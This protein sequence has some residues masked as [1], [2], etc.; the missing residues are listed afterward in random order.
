MK[1]AAI[2]TLRGLYVITDEKL[3][4]QNNFAETVEQA[5]RGGARIVQYRDKSTDNTK[6]LSQA[7]ALKTLCEKYQA[8]LIINDDVE[9]AL[10]ID[11]D[12]VHIGKHDASLAA[13]REQ[14]G[15]QKIIGVSCYNRFELAQEAEKQG[16][17]YI[18]FGSFFSSATKPEAT[19]AEITL[20]ARARQHLNIP[21][22]AIGGITLNN[23]STLITEGA[24]MLAVISDVFGQDDI[25]SRCKIFSTLFAS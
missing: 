16:A 21:V 25:E 13:T 12:G 15:R 8:I 23:A 4:P 6:R 24:D 1:S 11:A 2:K 3:I 19:R 9:L 5:L 17:D 20:L 18:A 7:A 22:C 10:Q 14:L